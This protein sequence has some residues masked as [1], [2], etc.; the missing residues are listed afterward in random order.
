VGKGGWQHKGGFGFALAMAAALSTAVRRQRR[1]RGGGSGSISTPAAASLAA[2]KA[3]WCQGG[4][5]GGSTI[6]NQLKTSAV[7][8]S[9]MRTMTATTTTLK[10]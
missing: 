1:K 6:N 8:A 5:S 4:I 2:A 9:E 7:T 10:T 3:A